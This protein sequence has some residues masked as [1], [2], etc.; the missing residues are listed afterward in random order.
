M[1]VLA[2]YWEGEQQEWVGLNSW[3]GPPSGSNTAIWDQLSGVEKALCMFSEALIWSEPWH[4][5][6]LQLSPHCECV[7]MTQLTKW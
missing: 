3:R 7:Y 5:K 4:C 2:T 1:T 6:Q